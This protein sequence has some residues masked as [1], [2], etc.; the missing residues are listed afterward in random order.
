MKL[1]PSFKSHEKKYMTSKN[2]ENNN[3]YVHM[4]RIKL[5]KKIRARAD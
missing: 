2:F 4:I 1:G 3:E 5:I